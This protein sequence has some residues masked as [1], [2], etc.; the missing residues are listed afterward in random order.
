[1]IG[2]E[3]LNNILNIWDP[4]EV[5]YHAPKDEYCQLTQEILGE[6]NAYMDYH[7][8]YAI[9]NKIGNY[10][11]KDFLRMNEKSCHFISELIFEIMGQS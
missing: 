3:V 10:Y 11:F 1:M 2:Y 4:L 5:M 8:I 6:L 7:E 9:I